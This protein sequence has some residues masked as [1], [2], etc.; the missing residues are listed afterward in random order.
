MKTL[1]IL[2]CIVYLI[3]FLEVLYLFT[4]GQRYMRLSV[5]RAKRNWFWERAVYVAIGCIAISSVIDT[6][7]PDITT[8]L[9]LLLFAA[10]LLL[11][12]ISVYHH[13]KH[14]T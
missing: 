14:L 3:I 11:K 12:C 2:S 7:T 1:P 4:C 10:M 8:T 13:Y 6:T 5:R 9:L